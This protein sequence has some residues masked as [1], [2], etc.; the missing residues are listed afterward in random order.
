MKLILIQNIWILFIIIRSFMDEHRIKYGLKINHSINAYASLVLAGV[1]SFIA[2][3][4][5]LITFVLLAEYWILFDML[6]NKLR[7]KELLYLGTTAFLDRTFHNKYTQLTVKI[8]CLLICVGGW[9][10]IK[11]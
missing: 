6:L 8:V 9:L 5:L 2:T 1:L 11:K 10:L 4:S 7:G 3:K